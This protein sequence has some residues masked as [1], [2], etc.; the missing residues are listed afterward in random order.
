M[1]LKFMYGFNR[2]RMWLY[3]KIIWKNSYLEEGRI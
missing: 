3:D 2:A 1:V